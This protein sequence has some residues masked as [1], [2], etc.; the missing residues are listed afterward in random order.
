MKVDTLLF[1]LDG[2]LIDTNKLIILSFVHTLEK[3]FPGQYK[4]DDVLK[5]MG[6]PLEESFQ[7]L[8]P[9]KLDE[10]VQTYRTFNHEKHDEL[11]TAFDGVVDTIKTLHERGY[12][13]GIVTTKIRPTV[14]M[15]LKLTGLDAYFDVVVTLDD[16]THAKPD[17]E[18]VNLA[19]SQLG[20]NV[21]SAMMIGDNSHDIEAGK[22]AN[23]LTAGV[24]WAVKGRE[25]LESYHP[26][27]ML[28]HPSDLL[29]IVGDET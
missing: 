7:E 16:V 3:Y 21:E 26:D 25:Y 24:A 13:L 28:E 29:S 5:F 8:N 4:E 14:E 1:D 23:V 19:L 15:G 22:N 2:T 27:Y 6:P 11:V 18:P 12:K 20:S 9:N 17:P 10:M